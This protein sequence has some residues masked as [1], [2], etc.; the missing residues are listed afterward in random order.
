MTDTLYT[1]PQNWRWF[2]L[3]EVCN[4]E[5]G[6]TFPANAKENKLT[7]KNIPCIRTA[8]VQSELDITDLIYIDKSY[9]KNNSAKLLK[10]GDIIMSSA[11]SRELVGKTCYVKS[12]NFEMR[13]LAD[14]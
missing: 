13:L 8:N 9:T 7:E 12:V 1:I 2:K 3:G 10:S 4:F 5:R 11:N 6:I 14:L